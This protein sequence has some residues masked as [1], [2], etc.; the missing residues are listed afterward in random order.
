[1]LR[2]LALALA[3]AVALVSTG[4]ARNRCCTASAS[5]CCPPPAPCCPAPGCASG[6]AP[7]L[8]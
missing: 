5:P 6:G 2:Y 1:M 4:C 7:V 3:L 8:H